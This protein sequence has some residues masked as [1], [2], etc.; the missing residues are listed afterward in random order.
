[1]DRRNE[2]QFIDRMH[3]IVMGMSRSCTGCLRRDTIACKTCWSNEA[4]MLIADMNTY[5]EPISLTEK[6]DLFDETAE[7]LEFINANLGVSIKMMSSTFSGLK[8]CS[9]QFIARKLLKA[10]KIV[11]S[12]GCPRVYFPASTPKDAIDSISKT[13]KKTRKENYGN[14]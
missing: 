9:L 10:K 4:K 3:S 2:Q 7:V 5:P 11:S 1:M 13:F 6:T 12:H 14:S 8:N